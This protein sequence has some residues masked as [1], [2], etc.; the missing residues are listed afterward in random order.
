MHALILVLQIKDFT[1]LKMRVLFSFLQ[2]QDNG[3]KTSTF[4]LHKCLSSFYFSFLNLVKG[5]ALILLH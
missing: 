5:L 4:D 3:I 2:L 1:R